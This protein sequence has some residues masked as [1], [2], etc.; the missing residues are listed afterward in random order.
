MAII[1]RV[2]EACPNVTVK[3]EAR[4]TLRA[5]RCL[6]VLLRDKLHERL[7]STPEANVS[8]TQRLVCEAAAVCAM[9]FDVSYNHLLFLLNSSDDTYE[10][11]RS[12]ILVHENR[13]TQLSAA[14]LA[15]Q[16]LL[17][18]HDRITRRVEVR[19]RACVLKDPQAMH[20]AIG[21][22]W[23]SYTTDGPWHPLPYPNER[24]LSRHVR[25]SGLVT[26]VVHFDLL[27]GRLLVDCC[28]LGRL[29]SS[30]TTHPTFQCLFVKVS[31]S[32]QTHGAVLLMTLF[33]S[34]S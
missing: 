32:R 12:L 21:S 1:L 25:K 14:P 15:E 26:Q 9:T 10:L 2:L 31:F 30:V 28:P 20:R 23:P 18:W 22:V 29:P 7:Q 17:C 19:L 6:V 33:S 5:A 13:P 8:T 34:L 27:S 16:L 24:Q 3:V 4:E 11:V